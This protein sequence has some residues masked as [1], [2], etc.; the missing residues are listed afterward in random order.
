M[1]A[2]GKFVVAVVL[3]AVPVL[4]ETVLDELQK[5]REA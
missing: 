5:K 1:P 4:V 2:L 3:A